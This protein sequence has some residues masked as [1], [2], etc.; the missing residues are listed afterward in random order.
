MYAARD[1]RGLMLAAS[2]DDPEHYSLRVRERLAIER[3]KR[4]VGAEIY[5]QG[6]AFLGYADDSIPSDD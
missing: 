1:G 5:A 3:L 4:R 2:I 6:A